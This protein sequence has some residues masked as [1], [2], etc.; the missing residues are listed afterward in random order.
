MELREARPEGRQLIQAYRAGGFTVGG[1]VRT[2]SVLILVDATLAWPPR[3]AGDLAEA[4]FAP[5]VAAAAGLDIV[6][7][8]TGA[9]FTPAPEGL[10]AALARAG[11]K[12]EPMATPAACRTYNLLVAEERRVAAALI[13]V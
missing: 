11:L 13:A 12:V 1:V 8:G 2:G 9:V 6:L 7:L 5:L 10:L 4:H 3:R